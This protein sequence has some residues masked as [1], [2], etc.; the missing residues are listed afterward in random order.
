MTNALITAEIPASF[1]DAAMQAASK[2]ETRYYLNGVFLDARGY[3]VATNGHIAF[4]AKCDAVKVFDGIRPDC[5]GEGTIC[6]IIIPRAAMELAAK[7][8]GDV[9]TVT[10]DATGHYWIERGTARIHFSPVVGSFPEWQRIV[11]EV[12]ETIQPA[13]YQPQYIA[14]LGKM[15]KAL[16][17]SRKGDECAFRIMQAGDGPAPV[18]FPGAKGAR[19]DVCAI[20]MPMRGAN[21]DG[22]SQREFLAA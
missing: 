22:W 15:A 21:V 12:P 6:G 17:D 13:H 2:E 8:K 10:R 20:I 4:S 3:V 19:H 5:L 7:G 11:P 16:R 18:L 9:C 1:I 14:A